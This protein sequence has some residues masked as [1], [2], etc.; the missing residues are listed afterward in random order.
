M[1]DLVRAVHFATTSGSRGRSPSITYS[2]R[3]GTAA[4]SWTSSGRNL[5]GDGQ[6]A[7]TGLG[8]ADDK[9][10]ASHQAVSATA[11]LANKAA[12]SAGVVTQTPSRAVMAARACWT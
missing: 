4:P 11:V 5:A 12:T 10:C 1:A 3:D 6:G 7:R 2:A 8:V 9:R